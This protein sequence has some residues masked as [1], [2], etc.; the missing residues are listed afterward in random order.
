MT[1]QATDEKSLERVLMVL[2]V[3]HSLW[4]AGALAKA[5]LEADVLADVDDVRAAERLRLVGRLRAGLYGP[6]H[7]TMA[8]ATE[9][10][11]P[12]LHY[13]IAVLEQED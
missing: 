1:H 7:E 9:R 2:G 13:A 4:S 8:R 10:Q 6:P 11:R 12:G 3:S 5:I